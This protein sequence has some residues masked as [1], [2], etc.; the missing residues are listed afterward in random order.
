M[1][2]APCGIDCSVCDANIAF[3]T[4]DKAL[5]QKMAE[6]FK[7]HFG[8]EIAPEDTCCEGCLSLGKKISF[9]AQCEIRSCALEKGYNTCAECNSLPCSKGEFIWKEGSQSLKTLYS[10][11]SEEMS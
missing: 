5:M 8:T 6:G 11:R 9:C 7:E 3:R 10:L 4:Q 1:K 2:H